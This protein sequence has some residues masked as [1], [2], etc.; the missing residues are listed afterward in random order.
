MTDQAKFNTVFQ[1]RPDK[2]YWHSASFHPMQNLSKSPTV[3]LLEFLDTLE[4]WQAEMAKIVPKS[5]FAWKRKKNGDDFYHGSE[6]WIL[7][8]PHV[9]THAEMWA[10]LHDAAA[11]RRYEPKSTDYTPQQAARAMA[12]ANEALRSV[13]RKREENMDEGVST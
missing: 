3:M 5:G 6:E 12:D 13:A 9:V 1:Q 8:Y 4:P 10:G 11:L 2:I 7:F